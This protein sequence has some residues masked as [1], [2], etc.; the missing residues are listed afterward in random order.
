MSSITSFLIQQ[1]AYS[2]PVL[3]VYL[4]GI[5]LGVIFI[6]KYPT[7]AMLTLVASVI[8]L[9]TTVGVF[10]A[11]AYITRSR[12]EYGWSTDRYSQMM[13]LVSIAGTIVRA[14]GLGLWL[15][16]VFVGRKSKTTIQ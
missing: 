16:A 10:L 13:S 3:I 2:A 5:V 15:A 1:L 4:A 8:L 6:K 7:P 14:V 11:Q 12:L 9:V